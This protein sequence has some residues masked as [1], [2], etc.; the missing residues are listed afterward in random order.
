MRSL[1]RGHFCGDHLEGLGF[2]GAEVKVWGVLVRKFALELS[3]IEENKGK[4]FG[5][6]FWSIWVWQKCW[7]EA[8]FE[9]SVIEEILELC[10]K[11]GGKI[12]RESGVIEGQSGRG[13]IWR[14]IKKAN[15]G[16]LDLGD[17]LSFG[18]EIWRVWS[19][20]SHLLCVKISDPY[21]LWIRSN[22]E[23]CDRVLKGSI[24]LRKLGLEIYSPRLEFISNC[25]EFWYTSCC[26]DRTRVYQ[27]S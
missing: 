22:G 12:R 3:Y 26:Q 17:R 9:R 6:G 11:F 23:I 2:E 24:V 4:V 14:A 21:D 7:I 19:Y 1:W 27:V 13:Q 25:A 10:V 18:Y 15:F 5:F 20:L 16:G 8:K